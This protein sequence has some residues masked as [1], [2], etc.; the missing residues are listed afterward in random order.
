MKIINVPI[1]SEE[2]KGWRRSVRP[3]SDASAMMGVS[4]KV[5]RDDLVREYATG[6]ERQISDYVREKVFSTGHA[7]E[8]VARQIA[9]ATIGEDLVR[10]AVSDDEGY[11]AAT[12]DGLAIVENV[13]WECK[14]WNEEKAACV[15]RGELPA[16]DRWQVKQQLVITNA[17]WCL[18]MVTDGTPEKCVTLRVKLDDTDAS[19]LVAGWRQFDGD[20]ANYR[21]EHK[22]APAVAEVIRDLP[23]VVVSVSGSIK[24]ADNLDE[25]AADLREFVDTRLIKSPQTDQDFANLDAQIKVL[26]RAEDALVGAGKDI[27]SRVAEIDTRIKLKDALHKLAR[28]NRLMAEK[29]LDSEKQNRR[30]EILQAAKDSLAAHI[31]ALNKRLGGAYVNVVA[32]FVGAMKGKKTIESLKNAANTTLAQAIIQANIAADAIDENLTIITDMADGYGFLCSDVGALV[33][34][35]KDDLRATIKA[36][37][38]DHKA[39]EEKRRADEHA[40]IR[41]EVERD[42]A[43][44]EEKRREDN[45]RKIEAEQSALSAADSFALM[46]GKEAIRNGD[47]AQA[48]KISDMKMAEKMEPEVDV[49]CEIRE[50]IINALVRR[51]FLT[52]SQAANVVVG[53]IDGDIP[54]VALSRHTITGRM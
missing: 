5:K 39:L 7:V 31:S 28:D 16:D 30:N 53:I 46:A 24:I 2:W 1:G 8:E 26:K 32:D 47:K 3:A 42:L 12:L 15:M 33:A 6:I 44:E 4:S 9:E 27:I 52:P 23:S 38:S 54:H 37:I 43:M 22:A 25:F 34:K 19:D 20:V 13:I 18:Y 51:C 45:R 48:S 14:Q 49:L 40:R 50:D 17:D 29:L 35:S 21:H 11:L 10:A 36:R 41:A